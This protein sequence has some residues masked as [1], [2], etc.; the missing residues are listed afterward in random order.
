M[1]FTK[2]IGNRLV[3]C[4]ILSNGKRWFMSRTVRV[5]DRIAPADLTRFKGGTPPPTIKMFKSEDEAVA[6]LVGQGWKLLWF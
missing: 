5:K 6:F 2:Y 4:Q 3:R 1:T